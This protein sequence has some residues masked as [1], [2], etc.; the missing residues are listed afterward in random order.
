MLIH[1]YCVHRRVID[2]QIFGK[3]RAPLNRL[4]RLFR[5]SIGRQV[6]SVFVKCYRDFIDNVIVAIASVSRTPENVLNWRRKRIGRVRCS[7]NNLAVRT[8]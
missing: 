8:V 7:D 1:L 5:L 3:S 4:A 2:V 6:G